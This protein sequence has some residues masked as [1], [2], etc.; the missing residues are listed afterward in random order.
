VSP[1]RLVAVVLATGLLAAAAPIQQQLQDAEKARQ[2]DLVAQRAAEERA[3]QAAEQERVL[4]EQRAAAAARLREAEDAL[5]RAATRVAD[6]SQR[7]AAAKARLA[8]TAARLGPMLPMIERLSL[9]P[10]ET[11]LAAPMPPEE[12]VRGAIVLNTL[13]RALAADA[14]ALR[15]EEAEVATLQAEL[16]AALPSLRAAQEEQARL[17]AALDAQLQDTRQARLAAEDAAGQAARRAAADAAR[18]E[19]LRTAIARIEA[20]RR[21]AEARAREEAA[22]AERRR[23]AAEAEAARAQQEA[24]ARPAGPGLGAP[25]NQLAV[26]VAGSLIRAFGAPTEAGP[27]TGQTYQVAPNARVVSPCGGR[28]VFA[29]RFRSFGL[30]LIVDCGGGYHVVLSGFDRL[31]VEVGQP[32]QPGEPVGVMPGWNP[33]DPNAQ[34][35]LLY[36][37][38]RQNG[39][40]VDP[41]PFLRVR[42]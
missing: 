26:P 41:A 13:T 23:Q 8:E 1:C 35:P 25:R 36:V 31:D 17:A 29:D 20:E 7:R 32:I 10:A 37:E 9:Y 28:V 42:S 39:E 33:R 6:L 27:A 22:A 12:A 5:A 38:L 18:A 19:S 21:A 15:A 14:A 3:R 4:G 24:L 2:A 34:R 30:L 11:L 16:D 40:P